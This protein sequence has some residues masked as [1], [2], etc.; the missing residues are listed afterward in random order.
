L[1]SGAEAGSQAHPVEAF[2]AGK[3]LGYVTFRRRWPLFEFI[4]SSPDA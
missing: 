2:A 1:W 4:L 3:L